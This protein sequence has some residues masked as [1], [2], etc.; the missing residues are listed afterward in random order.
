MGQTTLSDT[1][2]DK[3]SKRT[4]K[5]RSLEGTDRGH[6]AVQSETEGRGPAAHRNRVVASY[7]LSPALVQS[8]GPGRR[9]GCVRFSGNA[10]VRGH[11]PRPGTRA[12]RNHH[13]QVP[14][15]HG[16]AQPG[17][18]PV[19]PGQCLPSRE[20]AEGEPGYDHG[21]QHHRCTGFDEESDEGAGPGDALHAQGQAVALRH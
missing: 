16:A 13:L 14:P 6:R 10:T 9:G 21:C 20:R 7:P 5:E 2:F 19:R 12:G 1:G 3:F 4:C 17:G 8:L 15:P 18:S 11:R